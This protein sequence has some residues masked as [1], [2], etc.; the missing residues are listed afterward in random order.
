M[1]TVQSEHFVSAGGMHTEGIFGRDGRDLQKLQAVQHKIANSPPVCSHRPPVQR[2]TLNFFL[3]VGTEYETQEGLELWSSSKY[4]F[5]ECRRKV[6]LDRADVPHGSMWVQ[7]HS[8]S[9]TY[10]PAL[11]SLT[12]LP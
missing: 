4:P 1:E 9:S 11:L 7:M 2:F 3:P 12:F 10:S 8:E 5:V 6:P